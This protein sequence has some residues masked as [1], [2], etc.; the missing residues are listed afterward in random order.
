[1][2][3]WIATITLLL[4]GL[5]VLPVS[6]LAAKPRIRKSVKTSA[7]GRGVSYSSAKLSRATN[8]VIV[9]F[10]NTGKVG[11]ITYTLSYSANGIAQGVVGT[12]AAG[13]QNQTR[14]LYF[15]TCS[16]GVCTPHRGI[17]NAVLI[18]ETTLTTGATNVKRYIIRV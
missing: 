4:L 18:V 5:W 16:K 11:S 9:T 10:I 2:T 7:A 1:M 12:V 6:A 13:N 15:G 8:S 17:K 14:D 3:R